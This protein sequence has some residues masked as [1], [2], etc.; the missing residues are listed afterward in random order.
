MLNKECA[1]YGR[2]CCKHSDQVSKSLII[3]VKYSI[4]DQ[5]LN[6]HS[7]SSVEAYTQITGSV[8]AEFVRIARNSTGIIVYL[9][10]EEVYCL[11]MYLQYTISWWIAGHN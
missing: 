7:W 10:S 4:R 6:W 1:K 8:T 2:G 11:R 5:Y 9:F 3:L